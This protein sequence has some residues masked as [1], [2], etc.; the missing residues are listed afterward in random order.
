[1][2]ATKQLLHMGDAECIRFHD[3]RPDLG[4]GEAF[5]VGDAVVDDPDGLRIDR[6]RHLQVLID[7]QPCPPAHDPSLWVSGLGFK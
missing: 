6:L 3:V 5:A 2:S 7:P 4:W 1:M